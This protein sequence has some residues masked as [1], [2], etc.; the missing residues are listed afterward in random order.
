MFNLYNIIAYNAVW[1]VS[2]YGSLHYHPFIGPSMALIFLCSHFFLIKQKHSQLSV[3]IITFVSGLILETLIHKPFVYTFTQPHSI[4]WLT[5]IWLMFIWASFSCTLMYSIKALLKR[6]ISAFLSGAIFGPISYYGAEKIGV[7][8]IPN[9][10]T[11]FIILA[12]S[13]GSVMVWLRFIV[14]RYK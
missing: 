1:F 11:P 6:P 10:W 5:P 7:I 9:H 8:I 13:W 14:K 12:I 2:I 3:L 4:P